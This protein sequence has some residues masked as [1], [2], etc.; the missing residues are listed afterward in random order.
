[1][2]RNKK[3][4]KKKVN[5]KEK[6]KMKI[7]LLLATLCTFPLFSAFTFSP[8]NEG[9]YNIMGFYMNGMFV[10]MN[11]KR[12]ASWK[13]RS[14]D[15]KPDGKLTRLNVWQNKDFPDYNFKWGATVT[16]NKRFWLLGGEGSAG[17]KK[18]QTMPTV[19]T[20]TVEDDGT[21][22]NVKKVRSLPFPSK[23]GRALIHDNKIWYL[24]GTRDEL[25]SADI[26]ADGELGE[27]K[28]WKSY[29]TNVSGGGFV[30]YKGCFYANGQ[31]RLFMPGF[32]KMYAIKVK[33]DG[34]DTKW[35]RVESPQNA[36]GRL[37]VHNEALYYFDEVSGN[38]YKTTQEEDGIQLK[39]WQ[40]AGKL[41]CPPKT[42]GLGVTQV[43]DGWFL[44]GGVIGGIVRP[45]GVKFGGFYKG[46]FMPF[47]ALK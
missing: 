20:G 5:Y 2:K 24:G 32:D 4:F 19:I 44:Y 26:I 15:L 38:I 22:T 25:L 23:L 34:V 16:L 33:K 29:P 21:I 40:V 28:H 35:V 45:A 41:P 42:E 9:G 6:I 18:F 30:Y 17:N 14:D 43:P 46:A 39:A 36:M 8:P 13:Y 37:Y 10:E 3:D 1:M 7:K 11:E 47:S 31:T 27:W 12:I